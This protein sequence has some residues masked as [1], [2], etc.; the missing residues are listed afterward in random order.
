MILLKDSSISDIAQAI[1][2]IGH[3]EDLLRSNLSR[4]D[5]EEV[6]DILNDL[7]SLVADFIGKSEQPCEK[8]NDVPHLSP[9]SL[10][11][12]FRFVVYRDDTDDGHRVYY[13]GRDK[14]TTNSNDAKLLTASNARTIAYRMSLSKRHKWRVQE[15]IRRK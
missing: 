7:K 1:Q 11:D 9:D 5:R 10:V 15:K 8:D 2:E 6:E 13:A 12:P 3:Y 14:Y 4:K